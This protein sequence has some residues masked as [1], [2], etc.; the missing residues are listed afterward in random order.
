MFKTVI[1]FKHDTA[2]DMLERLKQVCAE[3][4]DNRAGK[5][6]G[7]E[8]NEYTLVFESNNFGCVSLANIDLDRTNS[9]TKYIASWR[10]ED[11]ITPSENCDILESLSK[12]TYDT[13]GNI[14]QKK[15][16]ENKLLSIL[17][18]PPCKLITLQTTGET[19]ILK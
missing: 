15:Y 12:P 6:I 10:W 1:E 13:R 17:T 14:C 18:P 19:D 3:A 7:Q 5:V 11:S 4:F 2:P 9:F 16:H 8:K